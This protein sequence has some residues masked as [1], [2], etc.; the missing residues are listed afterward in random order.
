MSNR[1]PVSM[2]GRIATDP[3]MRFTQSGQAVARF[4]LAVEDRQQNGRGN[5]ETTQTIF[6]TVTAWGRLAENTVDQLRKGDPI[7][8]AGDLRFRTYQ[9]P[10]GD[11]R[12]AT[13]V[14]ATTLGPDLRLATVEVDR[15]RRNSRAAEAAREAPTNERDRPAQQPEQGRGDARQAEQPAAS[16]QRTNQERSGAGDET[17]TRGRQDQRGSADTAPAT[18]SPAAGEETKRGARRNNAAAKTTASK[19]AQARQTQQAA[20]RPT[21]RGR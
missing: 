11:R 8:V 1:F 13:E 16:E 17:R 20:A 2:A 3:E 7:V 18:E 21:A 12:T 5:W 6:H 10:E 15:E 4:R 9:T 14:N 19:Q